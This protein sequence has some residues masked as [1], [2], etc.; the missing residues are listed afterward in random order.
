MRACGLCGLYDLVIGGIQAAVADIFS[1][2][3]RK[4]VGILQD[5]GNIFAQML[6]LIGRERFTVDRNASLF[7]IVEAVE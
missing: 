2:S 1:H 5:H 3:T 6:S 7:N 4:E